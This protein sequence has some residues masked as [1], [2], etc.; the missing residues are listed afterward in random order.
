VVRD[1]PWITENQSP[2]GVVREAGCHIGIVEQEV[3]ERSV[4]PDS[5]RAD[6]HE[7]QC[8]PWVHRLATHPYGQPK[9]LH[10]RDAA[11]D[12]VR[13][14]LRC[15]LGFCEVKQLTPTIRDDQYGRDVQ[16]CV[17]VRM[18]PGQQPICGTLTNVTKRMLTFGSDELFKIFVGEAHHI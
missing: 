11:E 13:H 14:C 5:L 7:P 8:A 4:C 16:G 3:A 15:R 9:S 17:C 6:K 10:F 12:R 18:P 2:R 1:L